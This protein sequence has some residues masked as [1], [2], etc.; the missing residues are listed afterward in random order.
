MPA[1]QGATD[2]C[3]ATVF[4]FL[5]GRTSSPILF[6]CAKTHATLALAGIFFLLKR[7]ERSNPRPGTVL[8]AYGLLYGCWRFGVEFLRA[9]N[10]PFALNLT[11]FQWISLAVIAVSGAALLLRRP[12]NG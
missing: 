11:I 8:L 9:D 6:R 10:P 7:I 12:R 3:G 1:P 5:K 2:P 4:V